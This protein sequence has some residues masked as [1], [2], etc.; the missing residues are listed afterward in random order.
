MC[1]IVF[2][3]AG[4]KLNEDDLY[5][6]YLTNPDGAGFMYQ[7]KGGITIKKGY[8]NFG[9]MMKAYRKVGLTDAHEVVFH[10]RIATSGGVSAGTC[11]PF[12]VTD[13]IKTMKKTTITTSAAVAHNGVLAH[14]WGAEDMKSA[15]DTML[16]IKYF[17][18]PH[19]G[20]TLANATAGLSEMTNNRFAVMDEDGVELH[21]TWHKQSGIY[22]SNLNWTYT[23]SYQKSYKPA[24]KTVDWR[25]QYY[26]DFTTPIDDTLGFC[27]CPTCD[28]YVVRDVNCDYCGQPL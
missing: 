27:T 1:V 9:Q 3:P 6:C 28:S 10:F 5:D 2:K 13:D 15:S 25:D 22:Y 18:S 8:F 20:L 11:H 24:R 21:G 14:A 4:V 17:L 12:P 26:D 7:S 23:Y 19:K 16:A